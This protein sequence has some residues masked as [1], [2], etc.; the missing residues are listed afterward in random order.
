MHKILIVDDEVIITSQLEALLT[1]VGH[2]VVGVAFSAEEAVAMARETK[3]DLIL[4]D[5]FMDEMSSGITAAQ[6][7]KDELDIPVIFISGYAEEELVSKAK[8]V[9]PL[10]YIMKPFDP[11]QVTTSIEV[12]LHKFKIDREF[13]E[14]HDK[15]EKQFQERNEELIK[16]YETIKER[17]QELEIRTLELEE[18]N[19]ALKMLIERREEDKRELEEKV[20]GNVKTLVDPYLK[21]LRTKDLTP[22]QKIYLQI[23]ESNLEDIIAPF[24]RNLAMKYTGLTPKEVQVAALVKDGKNTKQ[25]AELIDTTVRAV[26]FHRHSLRDKLDLRNRKVNLRT[27]LMS[28]P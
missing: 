21:K 9:E 24:L 5:I 20:L 1:S 2:T 28:L 14:A 7:I 22:T 13:K 12:A 27:F 19:V 15:L 11:N 17:Q 26:E 6:K 10:G 18:T 3:P 16:A 4:M 23:L 25:I 8:E